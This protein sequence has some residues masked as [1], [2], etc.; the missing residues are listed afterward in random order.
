MT[1]IKKDRWEITDHCL[2]NNNPSCGKKFGCDVES[3]NKFI[4]IVDNLGSCDIYFL[5]LMRSTNL[6]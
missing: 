3:L 4:T 6:K 2:C 5:I 1:R